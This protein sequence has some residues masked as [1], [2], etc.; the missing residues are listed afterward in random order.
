MIDTI[1]CTLFAD[2]FQFYVADTQFRADTG[3]IWTTEA[4]DRMLATGEDLLAVGT[5]RNIEV[6]VAIELL[7][8]PPDDD[9]DHWQ[10]VIDCSLALTSGAFVAMGC[11]DYQPDALTREITPGTYRARVSYRGLDTLSDDGLDG[12]DF[13]RVQLWPGETCAVNV[14]KRRPT[15]ILPLA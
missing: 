4:T 12:E 14:I 7:S 13:Y 1:N 9:F 2:Y 5:A 15:A 10:Q 6:P 3:E 8:A 11:T